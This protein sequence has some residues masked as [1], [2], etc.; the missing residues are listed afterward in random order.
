[1]SEPTGRGQPSPGEEDDLDEEASQA[2]ARSVEA[3]RRT[4][5]VEGL[6]ALAKAYR[7]GTEGPARDMA[8]CLECYRAAA[9]LGS[10]EAEYAVALFLMSGGPVE[11][12]WKEG[13]TRLRAAADKG[14]LGAKVY[15]ANLYELGIH[16]TQDTAKAD[17]WYRS[18]ARGA[19]VTAAPG[20]LEHA[21]AMAELGCVRYVLTLAE[22]SDTTDEQRQ[23]YLRKARAAGY[24]LHL[25][26]ERARES[27]VP[28]SSTPP[29]SSASASAPSPARASTPSSTPAPALA[30][31]PTP[32][33]AASPAAKKT[34]EQVEAEAVNAVKRLAKDAGASRAASLAAFGY[35]LLFAAA[36]L[37]A[38]IAAKAGVAYLQAQGK[39]PALLAEQGWLVLPAVFLVVGVLPAFLIYRGGAV[40]RAV[41]LGAIAALAGWFVWASRP[42]LAARDVQSVAFG[43][44]AFLAT[45]L[46]LGF[47]GGAKAPRRPARI[48]LRDEA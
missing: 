21:R 46:V 44:A 39:A 9:D 42:L 19:D 48:K 33:R 12:D 34:A 14:H 6:L 24:Q 43:A 38:G 23:R 32:A 3:L 41:A 28:G 18:A 25:R 16:Y 36:A 35:S 5:D 17:V 30:P 31:A 22:G 26:Q 37:G 15:V 47:F 11:Q 45:L 1:V 40:L 2:E 27:S 13:A 8:K 4:G 10:P 20:T 29:P 7:S